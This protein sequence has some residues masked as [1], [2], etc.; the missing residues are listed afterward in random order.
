MS[1]SN[2]YK[3]DT[4][5]II[6]RLYFWGHEGEVTENSIIFNLP[7]DVLRENWFWGS[8]HYNN[9]SAAR[10]TQMKGRITL[11]DG[12]FINF[13]SGIALERLKNVIQNNN[14]EQFKALAAEGL[15]S[16]DAG[17]YN[18]LNS[19]DFNDMIVNIELELFVDLNLDDIIQ[20]REDA[21]YENEQVI[22]D[23][24]D[25]YMRYREGDFS[26]E[27]RERERQEDEDEYA[28]SQ[29]VRK[30]KREGEGIK[31]TIKFKVKDYFKNLDYH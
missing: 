21:Y 1:A 4:P 3:I 28:Y 19:G 12:S 6:K 23:D 2:L 15:V 17:I 27:D 13:N 16:G 5:S 20:L 24:I 26:L 11:S 14:Y 18:A 31:E 10:P 9:L 7:R 30:R 22:D 8:L 25:S 29:M